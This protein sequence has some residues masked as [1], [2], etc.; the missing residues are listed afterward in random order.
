MS[1]FC[2][3]TVRFLNCGDLAQNDQLYENWLH[4]NRAGAMIASA[5]LA[6]AIDGLDGSFRWPRTGQ[7]GRTV[8]V[9]EVVNGEIVCLEHGRGPDETRSDGGQASVLA[10][11]ADRP[12]SR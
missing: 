2:G 4:L 9:R 10:P 5:R 3:N 11:S 8:S 12:A 7:Q 1:S 6:D